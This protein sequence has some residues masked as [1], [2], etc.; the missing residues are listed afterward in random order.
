MSKFHI[1]DRV[2]LKENLIVVEITKIDKKNKYGVIYPHLKAPDEF[3][4][5]EDELEKK[6]IDY[7]QIIFNA[8]IEYRFKYYDLLDRLYSAGRRERY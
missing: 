3:W 2:I 8:Y 7:Q 5:K 6:P 4:V 1:G